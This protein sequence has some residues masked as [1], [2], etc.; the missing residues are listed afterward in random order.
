MLVMKAKGACHVRGIM[1]KLTSP[2]LGSLFAC[3][4]VN[5]CRIP[6]A[7]LIVWWDVSF[8][9]HREWSWRPAHF[10]NW[11]ARTLPG[12]CEFVR[13]AEQVQKSCGFFYICCKWHKYVS[14]HVHTHTL[15]CIHLLKLI[16]CSI[17]H[18]CL[19]KCDPW[20]FVTFSKRKFLWLGY[21]R[22]NRQTV[23]KRKYH[24][25]IKP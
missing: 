20:P 18:K 17:L 15:A 11:T 23:Y 4:H 19:K 6:T 16:D 2:Y 13:T 24:S 1:V 7:G 12:F 10:L 25:V 14:K 3:V 8:R 9:S 21:S 5:I 22:E